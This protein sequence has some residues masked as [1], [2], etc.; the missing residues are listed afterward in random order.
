[1]V[2]GYTATEVGDV[3]IA[4][5]VEPYQRVESVL[6]W[7][8][9]A[10][11]SNEFTVGKLSFKSG[12]LIAKGIGTNLDLNQG[13]IILAAGYE[14]EVFSTP[15][16]FTVKLMTESTVDLNNVE[17]HVK[18]NQWNYF[19][20]QY[21]WSQNSTGDSGGEYTEWHE[22][23]K[24]NL[25]GDILTLD[26]N[27][28]A[29]FWIEIKSTVMDLQPLHNIS[30][31]KVTFT[32]QLE[33][34]TVEECPQ[35]CTECDPYDVIGCANIITECD[36]ENLYN[37]Y[38]LQ[39]PSHL[40]KSL[41]NLANTIYGHEVIYY[42]VEPNLRSK[43]VVLKE[44]SLYDVIEK[45][46]LKIMVPNNEFPTESEKFDMFGMGFEDFEVHVLGG[47][48]K[49]KFGANKSPR[50]RDYLYFPFNNKMYEVNS[51]ALA[52]EF[53]RTLTYFKVMLKKYENRTSTN[54]GEFEEDL[55]NLVVGVEEAFGEET[56][57][58]FDKVTKP[59][60]YH[61]THHMSQD[62][63]R[64]FVHK[65]LDIKDVNLMNKWTVVTRNYY[66]ISSLHTGDVSTHYP[67]VVYE[68][69]SNLSIEENRAF[70]FWFQPGK[71]FDFND[72]SFYDVIDGT[73]TMGNGCAVK[74][75]SRNA[76]VRI[77]NQ[78]Y[79]FD[80]NII[81]SSTKWY[82]M[83]VNVSNTYREV[84]IRISSLEDQDLYNNP[85][86]PVELTEMYYGKLDA[87]SPFAWETDVNWTLKINPY[88][89][90]NIRIF[91]KTIEEEQQTNVLHQY[92]VRDSQYLV[93]ADNA[94]PS[95]MLQKFSSTR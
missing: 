37:P 42:R 15:D 27:P 73:D 1:M 62:G 72:L 49:D 95:L 93:V 53:N 80:H 63:V 32:L 90:T 21:R 61:S 19:D 28:S 56:K 52:D 65:E 51:V 81:L 85:T 83:V 35:I 34:G 39:K 43:D 87:L 78:D 20:Y 84:S 58:E 94:I 38:G 33:D 67:A 50:S 69:K 48:F 3:I 76:M 59:L 64:M 66:N 75:S 45:A 23:N 89:L 70:S 46:N 26:I 68:A 41:S 36:S 10:G 74:L 79:V 31:L 5:F 92:V 60:Q 25:I 17:F 6:D 82:T 29:P 71:S 4:K 55:Q 14:F 30:F 44:Y 8:I 7:D 86:G 12:S 9:H 16:S 88:H 47:E 13:D 57:E 40:Y 2:N 11:F 18:T 91:S 54:K 22:L 24:T 77:N